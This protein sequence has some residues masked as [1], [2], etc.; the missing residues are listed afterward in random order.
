MRERLRIEPGKT[1]IFQ[2][3]GTILGSPQENKAR[4]IKDRG[5]LRRGWHSVSQKR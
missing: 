2:E 4:A 5:D 1:A 3:R